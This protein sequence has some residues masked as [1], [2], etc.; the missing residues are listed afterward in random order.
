M[1]PQEQYNKFVEHVQKSTKKFTKQRSSLLPLFSILDDQLS[2]KD[3]VRLK[4]EDVEKA[5]GKDKRVAKY[6][7]AIT[8]LLKVWGT[9]EDYEIP[10]QVIIIK[11]S[12]FSPVSDDWDL[13]DLKEKAAEIVNKIFREKIVVDEWTNEEWNLEAISKSSKETSIAAGTYVSAY[14]NKKNDFRGYTLNYGKALNNKK[15]AMLRCGEC[16]SLAI[17]RMSQDKAF[18][19]VPIYA[20]S[21]GKPTSGGHW[22]AVVGDIEGFEYGKTSKSCFV[23]DLWAGNRFA[24][25]RAKKTLKGKTLTYELVRKTILSDGELNGVFEGKCVMEC[26]DNKLTIQKAHPEEEN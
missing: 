24:T 3:V 9:K 26:D 2:K 8:S 25:T 4:K 18:A 15:D 16:T 20:V 6:Q 5:L 23:V 19:K 21:Q 13:K 7:E 17:Y 22:F 14:L 11:D 1:T 12:T 10:K